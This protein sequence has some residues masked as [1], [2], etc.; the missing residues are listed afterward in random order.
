MSRVKVTEHIHSLHCIAP[1]AMSSFAV[2]PTLRFPWTPCLAVCPGM[3]VSTA[4]V[5][6]PS[7]EI[8]VCDRDAGDSAECRTTSTD[9]VT[10]DASDSLCVEALLLLQRSMSFLPCPAA[11]ALPKLVRPKYY[12]KLHHANLP[13]RSA[14]LL[15]HTFL[16]DYRTVVNGHGPMAFVKFVHQIRDGG[17]AKDRNGATA[18][19]VLRKL[20][21]ALQKHLC[22]SYT[23]VPE[24]SIKMGEAVAMLEKMAE[25]FPGA[26]CIPACLSTRL[27]TLGRNGV[28]PALF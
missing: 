13:G 22:K 8:V 28:C 14:T 17:L 20:F 1:D 19:Y 26:V 5:S 10:S 18:K 27:S 16:N 2:T 11:A 7:R 21:F 4:S 6:L 15:A 24:R 12:K 25:D 9:A 3:A 23:L